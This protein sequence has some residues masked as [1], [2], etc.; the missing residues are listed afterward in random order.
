MGGDKL[1]DIGMYNRVK[2]ILI[3][4]LRGYPAWRYYGIFEFYFKGELGKKVI[5]DLENDGFINVKEEG[6]K[7]WY[8]LTS[9]GVQLA[10]SLSIKQKVDNL[11]YVGV[12]LIGIT[13]IVGLAH[14]LLSYFQN[15]IPIF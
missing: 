4:F 10:S 12:V 8:W 3:D 7:T 6:G 9:K 11:K 15:P 5:K 13:I 14:L 2:L 1:K